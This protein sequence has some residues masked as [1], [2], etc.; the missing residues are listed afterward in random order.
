MEEN[1]IWKPKQDIMYIMECADD[2]K[3]N[4]GMLPELLDD[5]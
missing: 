2:P 4:P 5:E 1:V 3:G